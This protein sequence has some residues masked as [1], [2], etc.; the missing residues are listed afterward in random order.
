MQASKE[1]REKSISIFK[2]ILSAYNYLSIYL[3]I[4]IVFNLILLNLPLTNYLGYEFSIFNSVVIILLAGIFS[5]FYLKKIAVGENTKNK[6]YKTLA[7]VSFIFLLLP[8]LISFVS[9]FKTVTCP[10]IDGII[11]YTFLTIPA[12]II[13]IALGILSYSLSKRISLLLF[14]LAFFII[15]LIPVFE[16]YFNP[17]VYF[18]NPIVGFFPGTIYDEGIEVDLKLMI[19]RI[20]NLLFFLSIIFLVLRAL[21]SSSRYS[22]KITWV[23][24]IIVPLAFIILSSDFGYSTTPSRI[25]AELDKTISSEHYEIHYSSAL[26]DTLISVIA[27]HHEFYYSELEKYFNVKPKKKIVS[28]IFN[29]REQK[30]RLFGTA[31]ADVAK[32]WIPEIYISVD[33]YDK[34]LKHEIAHCF[35]REFGSYIFKIADNF[36][37][38]LIEGVAMAADPVYD[39]FDL[40]YMAALAFNND[41]KLNVNALFTFFNFFKQPSSLGYIIAGSFIKFLIDKYGINQFKKLYT[42][43]DFVE[44]YGKELPMLAREHEIYLNDKY[45]IHA[46]AIDRAKYYYGRKSI[47]YKV[48]PRYVAKKIN[49]AWKLYDQKKIEDAKKIFKKLL[50][51][52]DN[53]SP[54][55]GLSYCYVELNE[56]QKAIYLLQENI[57]KFEKTAYQY[58]IQFLLA[59][60][61]AKNNRISEAHSIYKLLILQNPSRTL[62]SLSTLRADLIDADSLIVKYLNGEDEAKY[63]ILKSLNSTSYNYN[64]FPYLSSSAKSAKVEHENF[65]KNF[66]KVLEVTDQKSSYA[67]YRLSSY[68]CEKLDF[69]RARKMAALSLRYSEDVSFNSVLQS[70]FNKMNWLYKNSGEALS[71]MKYF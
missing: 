15:A 6:I 1:W 28:L 38:S 68:M 46:I 25:K 53:Y 10:I 17:Q 52:S 18:Y 35:T 71:K 61:L 47:F 12:P 5:I 58:E 48:C 14:L 70:N 29:N 50:T 67:I 30:K 22:L 49:E 8:F 11:F 44:H 3:L 26:N 69:N 42:D 56:N 45:G 40:D 62:Y 65:L 32:P 41:F 20:L 39:G 19:Y 24:S 7:W 59:D 63:G 2:R 54:L 57:H 64:S 4:L 51:I 21:V 27:L 23:Y 34:T 43:L 33:N 36:N 66:A 55:I 31:N 9:L 13:G 16:I 60:L 37:P